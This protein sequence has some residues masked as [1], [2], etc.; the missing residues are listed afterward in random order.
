M[1]DTRMVELM[2]HMM[3]P[4]L[5]VRA[6]SSNALIVPT[7]NRVENA[8]RLFHALQETCVDTDVFFVIGSEDPRLRDY[9]DQFAEYCLVFPQR[10]LVKALNF[11]SRLLCYEYDYLSWM[12]DDHL[13]H[14]RGWDARYVAVLKSMPVGLVYGNDLLQGARIPTQVGMTSTIIRTLGYFAHPSFTHLCFDLA[15]L[16]LGN[17]LG[18]ITYLDDVVI[19]HIHPAA[20]KAP[21]DDGYRLANSSEMVDRDTAAYSVWKQ[22]ILPEEVKALREVM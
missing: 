2:P 20:G 3:K 21:E 19:E 8:T 12:G 10:G 5:Q 1:T 9:L 6:Q 16:D 4:A 15:H 17:E 7:R 13:P 22:Q 18:C 14:T 11:A